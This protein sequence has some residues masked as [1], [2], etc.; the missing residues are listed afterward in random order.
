MRVFALMFV[1]FT[2]LAACA[3]LDGVAFRLSTPGKLLANTAIAEKV[4]AF[5]DEELRTRNYAAAGEYVALGN[6]AAAALGKDQIDVAGMTNGD[7]MR[8]VTDLRAVVCAIP[9]G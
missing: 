4:A 6:M 3:G 5:C 8:M 2:G 7:A 9:A 1:M